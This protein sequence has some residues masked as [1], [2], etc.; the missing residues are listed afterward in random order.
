M[1]AEIVTGELAD[2]PAAACGPTARPLL[3]RT[4][5]LFSAPVAGQ[6]FMLMLISLYLMKYSTDVL[7]LAPA[8][9]GGI[10]LVSRVWDAVSDPLVGIWSDR[11][12][13]RLGRRRP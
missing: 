1:P 8:A 11:T 4:L 7:G 6:G 9:M 10:F 5:L 13:T 3:L 2:S 12:T